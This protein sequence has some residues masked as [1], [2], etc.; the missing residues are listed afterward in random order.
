MR[1]MSYFLCL[2]VSLRALES[3]GLQSDAL[4]EAEMSLHEEIQ[5]IKPAPPSECLNLTSGSSHGKKVFFFF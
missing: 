4:Y 3:V 5:S 2:S 1:A